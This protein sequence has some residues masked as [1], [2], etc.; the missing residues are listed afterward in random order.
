MSAP[1]GEA[2]GPRPAGRVGRAS[3]GGA[4]L[5]ILLGY[6]AMVYYGVGPY[7][8]QAEVPWWQPRGF[9]RDTALVTRFDGR[10]AAGVAALALPALALGAGVWVLW[11]AAL[12]R[13]AALA[14]VL[15]AGLFAYYGL[16]S[17]G[18]AIWSFFGWR[19][20]AVMALFALVVAAAATAPWLAAAWLR[21]GP[22]LRAIVYAPLALAVVAFV[23]GA[24][25]T[26]P[27]L[28]FNVSPWPAVTIFGLEG[29]AAMLAGVLACVGLAL[30][31]ARLRDRAPALAA[32]GFGAALAVPLGWWTLD[33]GGGLALLAA[34]LGLALVALRAAATA[35][36]SATLGLRS[37]GGYAALGALLVAAPL[38]VG[39]AWVRWD[40]AVTRNDRAQRILD[41]L[42]TY[43]E[44][45]GGYPEELSELVEADLLERVP[46]PRVGFGVLGA[47][48]RFTYQNFGTDYLLEFSAPGWTQCAYTPPW[49]EDPVDGDDAAEGESLPGAWTCPSR[50]PE[51]W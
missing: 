12:A 49:E 36:G 19:G 37:P 7:P 4:V 21:R 18:P 50:P 38:L 14:C 33:L 43:S 47:D 3:A 22:V 46:A 32:G 27:S 34:T 48:P 30:A 15:A 16:S 17:R 40:Y 1:E 44:R 35:T 11:R 24:T 28:A 51:L 31:G 2:P 5:A 9:L 29:V 42:A 20:S 45:E 39:K 8:G 41:A 25:G 6:V 23:R 13:T 26:D 10:V